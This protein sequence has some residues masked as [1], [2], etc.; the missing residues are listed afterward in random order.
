M[1]QQIACGMTCVALA[2]VTAACT[3]Y[4]TQYYRDGDHYVPI[5][6]VQPYVS[7]GN[8]QDAH[9]PQPEVGVVHSY[10][11]ALDEAKADMATETTHDVVEEGSFES[12]SL[13]VPSE[14]GLEN[15]FVLSGDARRKRFEDALSTT[16]QG[17]EVRWASGSQMFLFKPNSA[18]YQPYYS[19]G[20]CRDAVLMVT[21]GPQPQKTRGLFCQRAPGASWVMISAL[22]PSF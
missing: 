13:W 12:F 8:V 3:P 7:A 22:G 21:G 18:I 15:G 2:A 9:A 20:R 6:R 19:G 17:G 4:H 10:V 14:G 16:P 1:K 11:S 5:Q